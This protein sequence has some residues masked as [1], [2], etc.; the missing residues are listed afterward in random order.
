MISFLTLLFFLKTEKKNKQTASPLTIQNYSANGSVNNLLYKSPMV[1]G[2]R[3]SSYLS[4]L[5]HDTIHA[6]SSFKSLVTI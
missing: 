4:V 3:R 2:P 1:V 5:F 6:I